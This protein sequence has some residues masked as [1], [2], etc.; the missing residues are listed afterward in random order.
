MAPW[1][2]GY[3]LTFSNTSA[4][5]K[6]RLL[7][8]L[9]SIPAA[10]IAGLSM[11]ECSMN[12]EQLNTRVSISYR[13]YAAHGRS[14]TNSTDHQEGQQGESG[15]IT[16]REEEGGTGTRSEHKIYQYTSARAASMERLIIGGEDYD[17]RKEVNLWHALGMWKYQKKLIATGGTWFLFD[18]CFYGVSLF[19]GQVRALLLIAIY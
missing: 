8:G 15:T 3:F 17:A 7:L 13:P 12:S 10:I 5:T 6:W 9:G 19:G 1:A 2:V 4:Q 11:W 16:D 18:V 14:S